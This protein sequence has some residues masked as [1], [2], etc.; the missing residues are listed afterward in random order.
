M[1]YSKAASGSAEN[2]RASRCL[3]SAS[4]GETARVSVAA[5]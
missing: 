2:Q 4:E 1:R 3:L 5:P